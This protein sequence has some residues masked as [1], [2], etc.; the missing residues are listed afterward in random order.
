MY[1]LFA[2]LVFF[3]ISAHPVTVNQ[4]SAT[5]YTLFGDQQ[6]L[7]QINIF[8]SIEIKIIIMRGVFGAFDYF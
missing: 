4:L 8:A 1:I 3:A 5:Y 2:F 7:Q 6:F